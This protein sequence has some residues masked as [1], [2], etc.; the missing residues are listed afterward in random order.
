MNKSIGT[1]IAKILFYLVAIV[2]MGWTASLTYTFVAA[3]LP[4]MAW[5]IPL[6]SLV[7]F[8]GGMIA[9][10]YVFLQYAEGSWQRGVALLLCVFDFIGV[11]L[12][13]IAEIL[14]GGQ[15]SFSTLHRVA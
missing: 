14:L 13:V 1:T 11:G 2:L 8:D 5:Y 15:T 4:E 12:M 9:W 7:V 10:M 3:A 6:L